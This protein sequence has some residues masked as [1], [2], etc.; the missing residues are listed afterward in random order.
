MPHGG[1]LK[2]A[3]EL[4]DR[5]E[6]TEY[7]ILVEAGV[8]VSSEWDPAAADGRSTLH[9]AA[10]SEPRARRWWMPVDYA[11]SISCSSSI[12]DTIT[13]GTTAQPLGTAQLCSRDGAGRTP[14]HAAAEPIPGPEHMCT[15]YRGG[16]PALD[17][18]HGRVQAGR[19]PSLRRANERRPALTTGTV[20]RTEHGPH[21]SPTH[22]W[23][24]ARCL[25]Q[26]P[27]ALTAYVP[28]SRALSAAA[29]RPC[30]LSGKLRSISRTTRVSGQSRW[31]C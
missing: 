19:G 15:G 14:I 2:L 6:P 22:R 25:I 28:R 16:D 31:A 27:R 9:A 24:H 30:R 4:S 29:G 21:A 26:M 18:L 23:G 1:L 8:D 7:R 5:G 20:R 17:L 12:L 13:S 3:W 10:A 11:R